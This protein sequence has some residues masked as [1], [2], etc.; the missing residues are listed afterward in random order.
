MDQLVID[1][2]SGA[3]LEQVMSVLIHIS[4]KVYAP[5]PILISLGPF[6]YPDSLMGTTSVKLGA[7]D[8]VIVV[9]DTT[10][11][12]HSGM[13]RG[14]VLLARAVPSTTLPGSASLYLNPPVMTWR[15]DCA[16]QIAM[17]LKI[18]S[19]FSLTFM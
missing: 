17:L 6:N 1:N 5:V 12:T 3:L 18:N 9:L 10:Q 16:V 2:T 8:L 13:G 4:V 14:V 15:L 19:Y 11:R 7:M